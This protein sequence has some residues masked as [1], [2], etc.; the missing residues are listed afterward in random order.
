MSDGDRMRWSGAGVLGE[1]EIQGMGKMAGRT[2]ETGIA[3][4]KIVAGRSGGLL[5][6]CVVVQGLLDARSDRGAV[7]LEVLGETW[8]MGYCSNIL[9]M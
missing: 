2:E 1:R 9:T 7:V 3:V 6:Q 8:M 5:N 4:L